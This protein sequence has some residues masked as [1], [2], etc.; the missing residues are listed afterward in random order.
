MKNSYKRKT[1][2]KIIAYGEE[3]NHIHYVEEKT[4]FISGDRDRGRPEDG[5][6]RHTIPI[7]Q[8][9]SIIE[10]VR[11]GERIE[12]EVNML[13]IASKNINNRKYQ[14]HFVINSN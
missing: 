11:G 14:Q 8:H 12:R 6:K 7:N 9:K 5:N 4:L 10:W 13:L 3:K 2:N 1:N